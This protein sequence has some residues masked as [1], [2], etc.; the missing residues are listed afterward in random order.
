[1]PTHGSLTKAGKVRGQTPK[2]EGR[3]RV[4]SIARIR[5]RNN[6]VK[7]FEKRRSPGQRKPERTG[8]R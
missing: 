1:M 2:I 6:F 4:S 8:R 5:N 7:R 3:E